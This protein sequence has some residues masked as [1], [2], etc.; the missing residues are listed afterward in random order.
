MRVLSIDTAL[1]GCVVGLYDYKKGM[2]AEKTLQMERG[3]AEQLVPM[4]EEIVGYY[5][6]IDLIAVTRGPGAFAGLRIGL[7]CAK[8][9]SMVLNKPV[10]G[11]ATLKAVRL[12]AN[13]ETPC[14]TLLETKRHDYY[15]QIFD[16]EPTCLDAENIVDRIGGAQC[17]IVGN[18]NQRFQGEV[19]SRKTLSF[20]NVEMISPQA[21]AEL[22]IQQ[23]EEN[24]N[25]TSTAP[26][27]LRGPEIGT[28]K[29][30]PRKIKP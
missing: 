14:V 29:R 28:P 16:E 17:K 10:V 19:T 6:E 27:Y 18:A 7:M 5:Q 2:L 22:A 21:I 24:P 12:T 11:V 3:Q 15:V 1:Q 23:Y 8:T 4:I 13:I 30:A 25:E 20:I 9:L 26:I